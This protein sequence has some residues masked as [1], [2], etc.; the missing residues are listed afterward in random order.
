MKRK[1]S[2]FYFLYYALYLLIYVGFF[3]VS[4]LIL[5]LSG[6]SENLGAVMVAT[7]AVLFIG[8]PTIIAVF[9]RFSLLRWYV[10]PFAAV[11]I[12]LCLYCGMIVKRMGHTGDF[13][14]AFLKVNQSLC[15]DSGSGWI[16]LIGL[17]L[18]SLLL[19]LSP[20]RKR[21]ESISYRLIA[22]IQTR[23]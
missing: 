20:A 3:L 23:E 17:F 21:G 9:M 2:V 14:S 11:E 13:S 15:S 22:K 16:F 5:D 4:Y 8:T 12:P 18:F 7:Y 10:D 19:S 6:A 1:M